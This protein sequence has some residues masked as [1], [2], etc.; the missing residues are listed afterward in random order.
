LSALAGLEGDVISIFSCQL[1]FIERE[2]IT[3]LSGTIKPSSIADPSGTGLLEVV[4]AQTKFWDCLNV[5]FYWDL[6]WKG[7]HSVG[8]TNPRHGA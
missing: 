5:R 2:D 7:E 3:I 1:L 4:D 6:G 8:F